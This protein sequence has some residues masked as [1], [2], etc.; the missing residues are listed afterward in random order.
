MPVVDFRIYRSATRLKNAV[1]V[2][3]LAVVRV[4]RINNA[5]NTDY[6]PEEISEILREIQM[7]SQGEEV[8]EDD[9]TLKNMST[10][11][12]NVLKKM[13]SLQQENQELKLKLSGLDKKFG[14]MTET[15]GE[16]QDDIA[17]M[18]EA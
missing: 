10:M 11:L 18:N 7:R 1:E 12:R 6:T 14:T 2:L 13:D 16:I 4:M 8:D 5:L 17:D 3:K 9:N 15:M